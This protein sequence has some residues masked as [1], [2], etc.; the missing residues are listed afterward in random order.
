MSSSQDSIFK[1]H[2]I[3]ESQTQVAS[4]GFA[5]HACE[6]LPGVQFSNS[7]FAQTQIAV[8]P[9]VAALTGEPPAQHI[10]NHLGGVFPLQAVMPT[11][12]CFRRNDCRTILANWAHLQKTLAHSALHLLSWNNFSCTANHF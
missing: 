9:A 7:G 6:Y 2:L 4:Q 5:L 1:P 8:N 3:V 12:N 10:N 11:T